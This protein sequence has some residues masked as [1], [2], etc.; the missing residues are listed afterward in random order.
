MIQKSSFYFYDLETSGFNPRMGRIMQFAGQRTDMDLNPVDEPDNILIKLTPDTLPDPD[1]ILVTGITPQ[2][3]ITD[4]ITEYE[5][6][7]YLTSKV[8]IPGT[9]MVGFNNVRF[10]DEFIRH[11]L[12][13]NFY[14]A[15]EWHWKDGSSRWDLL[16]VVRMTRAL[17]PDG[18]KWPFDSAQG[19]P[20]N[21]LELLTAINKLDHESAHDALSDVNATISVAKLIKTKQPKLFD[22]LLNLRDKKKVTALVTKGDPI[23]YTS[24][25]YPSE[26]EKTTVA[27]MVGAH[28]DKGAALMYDLRVD[29]DKFTNLSPQQLAELWSAWGKDAPYFPIKALSYN[30]CPAIAPLSVLDEN[31]AE[32]IKIDLSIIKANLAKLK[33]TADFDSKLIQALKL[34]QPKKQTG[35]AVNNQDVDGLLYDGFVNDSDKTKMRVVRAAAPD[36]ITG[37]VDFADERLKLLLPLYKARNF[38]KNMSGEEQEKWEEFRKH[39]LLDGG[40]KSW[41]AKYFKRVSELGAE[42]NA[43]A[44]KNSQNQYLLEELNLYGQAILPFS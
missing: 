36:E 23:I 32:R 43:D 8:C 33:K 6:T 24:G 18:I 4:G 7:D 10:D 20:S 39:R 2:S 27:V 3:T 26:Y 35:L 16:D 15:Y 11:T 40:E 14:D 30:K 5:F 28:P 13:R 17:R 29:P 12:W 42:L 37:S 31:S 34:A 21:R 22:Y 41:A 38:P 19:K 9:I 25:R 44:S 1:A